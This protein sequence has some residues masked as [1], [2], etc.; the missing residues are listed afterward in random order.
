MESWGLAESAINTINKVSKEKVNYWL[1]YEKSQA[2]L[3]LKKYD[4]ALS[5][6]K[7]CFDLAIEKNAAEGAISAYHDLLSTCYEKLD[8][9][10]NAIKELMEQLEILMMKNINPN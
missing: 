5:S 7:E 1:L 8:D 4:A 2:Y 10:H 9:Q 3:Q 6:A